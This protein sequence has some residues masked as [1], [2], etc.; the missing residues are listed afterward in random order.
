MTE[1][2]NIIS[3]TIQTNDDI[4][5]PNYETRYFA[6]KKD[7]FDGTAQGYGYKSKQKLMIA[8]WYSQN[9]G[10]IKSLKSETK[11]FM[12]DNSDVKKLLDI[13]FDDQNCLYYAKDN[14]EMSIQD[15]INVISKDKEIINSD[16]IIIKLNQNKHLWKTIMQ[17]DY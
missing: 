6:D 14:E 12:K 5:F 1:Q 11:K 3:K 16:E 10:K 13:Y 15:F 2:L 9:K 17:G 7:G 4:E 8:Y